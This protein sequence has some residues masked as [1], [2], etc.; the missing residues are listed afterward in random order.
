MWPC[1]VQKHSMYR[2]LLMNKHIVNKRTVI[3]LA[4]QPNCGKSTIFNLLTGARQYV[5]NYPGVTVEKLVGSCTINDARVTVVDL[6]GTYAFTSYSPEER[7]AREF[8]LHEHPDVVVAVLDAST[9]EKG[10][11]FTL[12]L[13]EMGCPVVVALN[14]AD[15]AARRG[16][17]LQ[18]EALSHR[19]GVPVVSLEA[20]HGQGRE[21]LLQ[22]IERVLNHAVPAAI[23][24]PTYGEL[25]THIT[26]LAESVSTLQCS[27]QYPPRW[28][29]LKLLEDDSA[30]IETIRSQCS[31]AE[32][33]FCMA[34]VV[35]GDIQAA[36]GCEARAVLSTERHTVARDLASIAVSVDA[37]N[38]NEEH[39]APTITERIDA[40]VCHRVAG[41]IC[42]VAVLY[43]F[44]QSSVV[45]GN[46]LAAD[47]WPFWA[48]VEAFIGGLL[49]HEGFLHDPLLTALGTWI[50][51][52]I[53]AVL[54]YL[55]IFFIMFAF[56]A[57]LED[58]GYLARIAFVLDRIFRA[59]GLHGQS[60]LPLILGG[61]YVGGCAIPGVVATR[62][63]PD[64]RARLATIMIVPMM[65]CLAK[66]PLYLLLIGGFFAA[67]AGSAMFFMGTVTL[68]MGLIV[69]KGLT[70]T[71]LRGH[72]AAPFIIELPAYH[73]PTVRGVLRE[74]ILRIWVFIQKVMTVVLAVAVVVFSLI[75]FPNL[76]QDRLEHYDALQHG[77]EDAFLA[78]VAKTSFADSITRSDILPLLRYQDALRNSKR[79]VTQEE[80][81]QINAKALESSPIYASIILRKGDGKKLVRPLRTLDSTRK[82]LRREV[83]QER[84]ERSYLGR[85]GRAL[86][87]ITASAGFT[88]RINVAL[89]SALAAKENSA[90][91]LGALYGFD[92]SNTGESFKQVEG[93]FTPLH[94]LALMLFMALYPPCL[95]AAMMVRAQA[96]STGWML[97]SIVFQMIIGLS[98][99][100][101]VY[102]GGVWLGLSGVEAMWTFYGI[103]VAIVIALAFIPNP[104]TS[105]KQ[106]GAPARIQP[107]SREV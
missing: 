6:P 79:G 45:Y 24:L 74:T 8:I 10:L 105:I 92:A 89:L 94:A 98:V 13:L 70:L 9:P 97:F 22:A 64:E 38:K 65:N 33:L 14:M 85:A 75:S 1:A 96:G 77:A 41:P 3:A 36:L 90:A 87:S 12:Q 61:I 63:I 48:N 66:V 86:E 95:P 53:T 78:Q 107:C 32:E 16:M 99:A 93:G 80:A 76:P 101:F 51:K 69:A 88:W 59:Y 2:C 102:S 17:K 67:Q 35:R 73:L 5:A 26:E 68:L 103:C 34:Q 52:S 19:L 40:V 58:S 82:T 28:V 44:Y 31:A 60:T 50:V 47:I 21:E 81:K 104:A 25:E 7:A 71:L 11:Y 91:T 84:F 15:V 29:A 23:A 39:T 4:G 18:M 106:K 37:T 20:A 42:L 27:M 30:V 57:I 55:P 46:N 100:S 54:N 83:R 43:L 49:P 72:P 62:A 56:V